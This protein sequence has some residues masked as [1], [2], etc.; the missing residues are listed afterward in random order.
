MHALFCQCKQKSQE[1]RERITDT[2][3]NRKKIID[4]PSDPIVLQEN[5]LRH[6]ATCCN[7]I[8][9]YTH[10]FRTVCAKVSRGPQIMGTQRN[11]K[12][13]MNSPSN[14]AAR[15]W[16]RTYCNTLQHTET[17]C[18]TLHHIVTRCNKRQHS[19][20]MPTKRGVF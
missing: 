3:R 16:A 10:T 19:S 20:V 15:R 2:Q 5:V 18:D 1:D 8:Y 17:Y 6:T 7:A 14:G 12:E 4:S 9:I 13:I 11:R